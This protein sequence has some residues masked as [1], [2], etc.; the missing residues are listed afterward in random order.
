MPI[1]TLILSAVLAVAG[2]VDQTD[3][4]QPRTVESH[5]VCDRVAAPWGSDRASGT[6]RRPV[7]SV[8]R[9][10]RSVPAGGTGCLRRGTYTRRETTITRERVTLQSAPGER[11]TWRGRIILRGRGDRLFDLKLDGSAGPRCTDDACGTLPSPTINAADVVIARDDITSPGSGICVHPRSWGPQRPDG[12]EIVDNRIHDCG[13]RPPTDHDHG[14]YV[15]DGYDGV[16]A[17]NAIFDNADRGIQLYPD[18]KF[19]TVE[20]NTVDGNGSGIIISERSS[21]NR[22]QDNVFTNSVVRWNAETYRLTGQGNV[23]EH[24][25]V[26]PGNRNPGYDQDGGLALPSTVAQRAN[27]IARD[28]VY[29]PGRSRGDLRILPTSACAGKGAPS[30]VAAP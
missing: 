15:A 16:I 8:R 6:W 24:N 7:R 11:A 27:T 29:P 19:T 10:V 2:G 21:G 17:E 9:L 26:R 23:F 3:L 18:A 13:R 14:I 4:A 30:G 12:F 28:P 5:A 20:H 25:C 1:P 22:I